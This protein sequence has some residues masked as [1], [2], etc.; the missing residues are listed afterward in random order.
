MSTVLPLAIVLGAC[1]GKSTTT[2]TALPANGASVSPSSSPLPPITTGPP[3]ASPAAADTDDADPDHG[4][5]GTDPV[6]PQDAAPNP[7]APSATIP[8]PPTAGIAARGQD[9]ALLSDQVCAPAM[10]FA[11]IETGVGSFAPGSNVRYQFGA[12]GRPAEFV[13]ESDGSVR[14]FVTDTPS[15][16]GT[17]P[18]TATDGT[19]TYSLT[20]CIT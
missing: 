6:R 16:A 5:V 20:V 17:Y 19:T 15:E 10:D 11:D 2:E 9:G 13:A 12:A 18:V 14:S 4:P 7:G 8:P 1:S 3:P